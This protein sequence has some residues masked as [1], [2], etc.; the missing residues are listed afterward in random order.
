MKKSFI[1][2]LL[3]LSVL[4]NSCE[5]DSFLFNTEKLDKYTLP[6]NNIPDSLIEKVT[7]K[8]ETYN[9]YGFWIK[10]DGAYPGRTI[11]YCHGNKHNIDAYW[12]RVMVMHKMGFNVFIF[13]YRGFGMSEGESSENGMY[14]DAESAL[15]FVSTTKKVPKD[16]LCLYGYSLGN[17]ASI[18][19]AANKINSACLI[20]EAPFASAN[21][22]SQ[23]SLGLDIPPDWLTKSNFNNAE[24]IKKVNTR[25]LLIQ[26]LDDDFVRYDDNGKIVF[27]NAPEP[28]KLYTLDGAGHTGIIS[29]IGESAYIKLISD[30]FLNN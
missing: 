16:S 20:A 29:V 2:L 23:G 9:L 22:L 6:D 10:S 17:V 21:S 13:D 7:L 11:L 8:S 5:L 15:D 19:L 24:L 28:K 25:F 1:L 12:D 4:L 27:E 3:L 14:K 18:Y 30:W 26:S